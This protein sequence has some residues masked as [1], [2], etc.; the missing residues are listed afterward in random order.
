MSVICPECGEKNSDEAVLCGMC[1]IVLRKIGGNTVPA[2]QPALHPQLSVPPDTVQQREKKQ[3]TIDAG[4]LLSN[5]I[6][7]FTSVDDD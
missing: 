3:Q 4:N 7:A 1:G 6:A 5:I 2:Q